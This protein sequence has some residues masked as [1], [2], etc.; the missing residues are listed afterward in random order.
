M[1]YKHINKYIVYVVITVGGVCW[2]YK[3]YIYKKAPRKVKKTTRMKA[4]RLVKGTKVCIKVHRQPEGV[5][6]SQANSKNSMVDCI[7]VE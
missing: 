5:K 4:Y 6:T 2:A 3:L 7:D 1:C